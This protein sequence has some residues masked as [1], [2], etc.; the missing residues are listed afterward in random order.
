MYASI[1]KKFKI[2]ETICKQ[3]TLQK[4]RGPDG[5]ERS[6]FLIKSK[7]GVKLI[8]LLEG[9]LVKVKPHLDRLRSRIIGDTISFGFRIR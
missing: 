6:D 9:F 7:L 3:Y 4:I 2:L 1:L 5:N 8:T